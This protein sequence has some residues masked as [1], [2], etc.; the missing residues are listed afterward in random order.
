MSISAVDDGVRLST[1]RLSRYGNN[2]S[3]EAA[4]KSVKGQPAYNDHASN[5][6]IAFLCVNKD[7]VFIIINSYSLSHCDYALTWED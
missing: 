2:F 4:V 6:A 7:M 3:R 5:K 1:R